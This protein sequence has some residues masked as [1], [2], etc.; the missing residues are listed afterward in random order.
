MRLPSLGEQGKGISTS[1]NGINK[2][3]KAG[4]HYQLAVQLRKLQ[5]T[6]SR[7]FSPQLFIGLIH[8]CFQTAQM[9]FPDK[10][11]RN[12][13]PIFLQHYRQL[14]FVTSSCLLS[15]YVSISH[16]Y[17]IHSFL[18]LVIVSPNEYAL[19]EGKDLVWPLLMC[20]TTSLK[21]QA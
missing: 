15:L 10:L 5:F 9:S 12:S 11:I 14:L 7:Q 3:V 13:L 20:S 16:N 8:Q 18:Y 19:S 21:C 17:F 2:E 6:L 4:K 1:G